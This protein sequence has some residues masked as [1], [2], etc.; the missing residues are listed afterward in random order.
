M[1]VAINGWFWDHHTGSGQYTRQLL[2]HLVQLAPEHE[3]ILVTPGEHVRITAPEQSAWR[4]TDR[5]QRQRRPGLRK[6]WFE[7]VTFPRA[8]SRLKADLAHVP[9]WGSPLSP[10]V[11][12]VV[13]IHDI[14]PLIL[15]A[16]RGNV[17]VRTYTGLVESAT[18]KASLVL[19]DSEASRRD[20]VAHLG[21]A[22][23]Q[24]RVVYLATDSAYSPQV[25]ETDHAIRAGYGLPEEYVLFLSGFDV[26]KNLLGLLQM[27]TFAE[28]LLGETTPLVIGGRL[29]DH[30]PFTPDPRVMAQTLEIDPDSLCFPGLIQEAHK[31]AIYRGAVCFVFP[32]TYEGFGL[33]P[34]EAM[35]CGVP[36]VGS[37][38][39]SIPEVVGDAGILVDPDDVRGMAGGLIAIVTEPETRAMLSQRALAQAAQFSWEKTARD[40]LAAYDLA[41]SRNN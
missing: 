3:F 33:P 41:K 18:A 14:I 21:V 11:P 15:P 8:C 24:V 30:S 38:A 20:I 4:P 37:D 31:P 22:E 5:P 39:S 2:A 28:N 1:R 35:S 36:V 25:E 19:T 6:V 16:Y 7:Q 32:S 40:T 29:P 23:E 17:L 27:W 34:L 9:Y 12:T 13:T 10:S 26:R